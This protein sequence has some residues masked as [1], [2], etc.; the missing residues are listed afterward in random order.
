MYQYLI[1]ESKKPIIDHESFILSMFNEFFEITH[2]NTSN[3]QIVV[4]FEQL[5][6]ISF[7][8][9]AINLTLDL[10]D[11]FRIYEAYTFH[12]KR[13]REIH[14]N[15]MKERI[16]RIPF[17]H[18]NYLNDKTV[19][20]YYIHQID[21]ELKKIILRK[22]YQDILMIETIKAYLESDQNMVLASKKIYVHRN[23]LIQRIDKFYQETGFDVRKFKDALLIY[24][25]IK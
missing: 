5:I 21:Q 17:L 10:Y 14:V 18:Y 12:S 9:V 1:I 15:L 19:L 13:D 2:Y 11:D 24:H 22:Y 16:D 6:D 23:T 8:E 25:L 3:H 4:Y 7:K 20:E